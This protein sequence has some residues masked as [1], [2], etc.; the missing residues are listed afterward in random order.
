[1]NKPHHPH[2]PGFN[3]GPSLSDIILGICGEYGVNPMELMSRIEAEFPGVKVG[4]VGP[5]ITAL[6]QSGDIVVEDTVQRGRLFVAV[7][8]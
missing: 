6:R 1:M 8:R 3:P 4:E 7:K 5:E 2:D